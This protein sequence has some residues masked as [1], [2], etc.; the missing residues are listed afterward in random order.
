MGTEYT[1]TPE[2]FYSVKLAKSSS[3]KKTKL[4][5]IALVNEPD[6]KYY[7]K[8]FK[9]PNCNE[10]HFAKVLNTNDLF[11]QNKSVNIKVA[12]KWIVNMF[13]GGILIIFL[14]NIPLSFAKKRLD[15]AEQMKEEMYNSIK[16]QYGIGS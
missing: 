14:T 4:K 15:K 12:I 3:V 1:V 11:E 8:K 13:I 2:E 7:A 9:C 16:E 6:I 10:K 5:G